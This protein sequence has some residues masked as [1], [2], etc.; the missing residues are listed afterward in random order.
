MIRKSA[1]ILLILIITSCTLSSMASANGPSVTFSFNKEDYHPGEMVILTA[2]LSSPIVTNV[3]FEVDD[4]DDNIILILTNQTNEAGRTSISFKLDDDAHFGDYDVFLTGNTSQGLIE[5]QTLFSVSPGY[6]PLVISPSDITASKINPANNE[7]ITLYAMVHNSGNTSIATTVSFYEGDP[8]TDGVLIDSTDIILPAE[9]SGVAKIDYTATDGNRTIFVIAETEEFPSI[10]VSRDFTFGQSVEPIL[11]ISS[12]D[13]SVFEFESG[14][15]RTISVDVTCHL[16]TVNNVHFV[17]LDNQGLT[18]N[19]S[20]TS[21]RTMTAGETVE[22]QLRI[23]APELPEGTDQLERG[24]LIQVV[25]DD[26]VFSDAETLNIM[27]KESK[28]SQLDPLI[29]L[30][31]FAVVVLIIIV[32]ILVTR[33]GDNQTREQIF[34]HIQAHPGADLN[35]IQEDLK[36]KKS[37]L[38]HNLKVLEKMRLIES[39]KDGDFQRYYPKEEEDF[40]KN[41]FEDFDDEEI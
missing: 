32:V 38:V 27:V 37:T 3:T 26:G 6:T 21:P 13:V 11:A 25:G 31:A 5:N 18:I 14:E 39:K 28:E 29:M 12:G 8:D 16:Q 34:K 33:R 4:T 15:E 2:S 17:I 19:A 10:L 9:S 23:K 22:F 1:V 36:T 41:H 24:I 30:I 35:E 7:K 40:T 20:I